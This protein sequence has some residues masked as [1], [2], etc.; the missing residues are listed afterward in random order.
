[1]R[2]TN[3]MS[4]SPLE[5]NIGDEGAFVT[6]CWTLLR[7]ANGLEVS[8]KPSKMLASSSYLNAPVSRRSELYLELG[9]AGRAKGQESTHSFSSSTS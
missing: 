1:V 9:L 4:S 5:M 7:L 8:A 6:A 3:C 2:A